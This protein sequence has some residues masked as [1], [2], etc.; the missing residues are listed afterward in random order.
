VRRA[1]PIIGRGDQQ[2]A[3]LVGPEAAAAGVVDL[4]GTQFLDSV[5]KF[6]TLAVDSF[7]EPSRALMHISDE[8]TRVV[9]RLFAFRMGIFQRLDFASVKIVSA[10]ACNRK[11]M[12]CL[13][14]A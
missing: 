11:S 3:E 4:Q 13:W 14:S 5:L 2:H 12:S 9:F 6:A 10:A 8:E 1:G 7:V